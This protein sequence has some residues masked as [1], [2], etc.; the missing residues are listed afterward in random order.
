[1]RRADEVFAHGRVIRVH[2]WLIRHVIERFIGLRVVAEEEPRARRTCG[3]GLRG[4]KGRMLAR[5][6]IG[7]KVEHNAQAAA[8]GSGHQ[9]LKVGHGAQARLDRK[10]IRRIV[11]MVRGRGENG[12]EPEAIDA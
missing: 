9:F 10:V 6:V 11:A 2:D 4:H 7:H 5:K 1:M 8:M 12:R 3:I